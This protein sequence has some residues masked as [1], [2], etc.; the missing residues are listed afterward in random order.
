MTSVGNATAKTLPRL[1]IIIATWQAAST[2]ERCLRSIIEQDFTDWE[3]L[4]ADGASTDGTVETIRRHERHIAWW[5]SRPDGGIYDAWNHALANAC[6][7][8]VTFLGADDRWHAQSTLSRV[9][10]AIGRCNYDLITGRGALVD[11]RG[12][13]YYVTGGGWDYKKVRRRMTICHPGSIYH[14]DLFGRFGNFDARYRIGGDYDFILRLPADLKTLHL[15]MTL[16]DMADSGISRKRRWLMLR[17]RYRAQ[18]NCPR[19]GRVRAAFNYVDKLWRI[20]VA[21]VLGI[22]N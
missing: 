9:F 3:V 21:K 17:E 19:V 8:Y 6:G 4:I 18:V 5:Q 12:M 1:S 11:Q 14:R 22:P 7:E 15:D 20:P 2:L 16:V 13:Q 10:E